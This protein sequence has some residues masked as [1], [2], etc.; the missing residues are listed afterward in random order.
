MLD[1]AGA[2]HPIHIMLAD[3]DPN[4]RK[5]VHLVRTFDTHLL[6]PGQI[7][8]TATAPLRAVR[9]V[10]IGVAHPRPSRCPSRPAAF[11]ACARNSSSASVSASS[12]PEDHRWRAAMR[13]CRCCARP[14]APAAAPA[15]PAPRSPPA[16]GRSRQPAPGQARS[17]PRARTPP[18]LAQRKIITARNAIVTPDTPK[19]N[20]GPECLLRN[21]AISTLRLAGKT[22][23]AAALRQTGRD[24]I[25]PL[26]L[27][28]IHP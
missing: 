26:Q 4:L 12:C 17:T 10:L 27:L 14:A 20:Y 9:H 15:P 24:I 28:R 6:C 25:R 3:R 8:P 7:R 16:V 2:A 19:I 23:I 11:P 1:A 5:I 22:N 21:L 18:T 13:S